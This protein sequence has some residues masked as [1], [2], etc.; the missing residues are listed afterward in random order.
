[1]FDLT[2]AKLFSVIAL[3]AVLLASTPADAFQDAAMATEP[4]PVQSVVLI[5]PLNS[6]ISFVG[7][8]V[9]DDPKPRL[10]GFKQFSGYAVVDPAAG[11]VTSMMLDIHVDSV[12]TQFDKLTGHL[13]N[14]DF[15][16]TAKFPTAQFVSTKIESGADGAFNITGNL[17]MHGVTKAVTFPAKYQVKDGALLMNTKFMLDRSQFGMDQMLS[18][19]EKMVE[20]EVFVGQKTMASTAMPGHGGGKKK[21]GGDKKKGSGAKGSESKGQ[22]SVAPQKLQHV[23]VKLPHME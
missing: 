2:I 5:G 1:M 13:K 8:H 16:D 22:S 19:V 4:V 14:A 9:G 3:F 17:T 7:T 12:W 21:A 6:R 18:G 15:F 20:V 10:G 23:A 11:T